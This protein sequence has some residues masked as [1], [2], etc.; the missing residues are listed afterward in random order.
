MQLTLSKPIPSPLSPHLVFVHVLEKHGAFLLS[1]RD[2]VVLLRTD[3]SM[4]LI[5]SL[6]GE[7]YAWGGIGAGFWEDIL[8]QRVDGFKRLNAEEQQLFEQS[9]MY[10][11]ARYV[12][13]AWHAHDG[14]VLFISGKNLALLE[15]EEDECVE[16]S[17]TRTKGKYP[18]ARTLS[19]EQNLLIYGTNHG[20]LYSQTFNREQFLKSRKLDQLSNTVYQTTFSIDGRRLLVAGLGFVKSYNFNGDTFSPDFAIATPAR[21]FELVDD[22]LVLNKGMHGIDVIHVAD[23]PEVVTSLD[24]SCVIDKMYYL[25]PQRTFLL[26]ITDTNEW[27]LLKITQ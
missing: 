4:E 19:P 22:Y 27:A 8:H 3:G 5:A 18:T 17:R 16:L 20:E 6:D 24:C 15:W 7:P 23:K 21:A 14:A 9:K 13:A 1:D 25:A 2:R 11:S 12:P 10:K 26:R